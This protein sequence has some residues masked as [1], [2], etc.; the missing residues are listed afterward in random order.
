MTLT[1]ATNFPSSGTVTVKINNEIISGTISGT[2]L[3][4]LTRGIGDS[5]D[6]AHADDDTVELYMIN[7]VPLTEINKTHTSIANINICTDSICAYIT[8]IYIYIY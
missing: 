5:D 8:V 7:S 2:E 1:S 6:A 4:S 3:S